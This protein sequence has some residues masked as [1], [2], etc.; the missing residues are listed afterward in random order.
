MQATRLGCANSSR[1]FRV[2]ARAR[3]RI[4]SGSGA[5]LP[6][7][8]PKV[9]LLKVSGMSAV[10]ATSPVEL[11]THSAMAAAVTMAAA[12]AAPAAPAQVVENLVPV[13][14]A[15]VVVAAAVP[16]L[17]VGTGAPPWA[18]AVVSNLG[19]QR[20]RTGCRLIQQVG[21]WSPVQIG[22]CKERKPDREAI[23]K[24][25]R[26]FGR[27]MPTENCCAS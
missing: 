24:S 13:H 26:K 2:Q 17:R 19:E 12:P 8:A 16:A 5:I 27:K 11:A 9:A 4:V 6:A 18:E 25:S 3:P 23:G 22:S 21:T 1:P 7:V 20:W 15:M 10:L 14:A